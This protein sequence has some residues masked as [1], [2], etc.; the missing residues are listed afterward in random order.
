MALHNDKIKKLQDLI[1]MYTFPDKRYPN[2]L[3]EITELLVWANQTYIKSGIT[4]EQV[5]EIL[6]EPYIILHT[7]SPQDF[8]WLYPQLD[9]SDNGIAGE[10]FLH[11][12]FDE[13]ILI[14]I[15]N[16]HGHFE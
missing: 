9:E 16:T 6:G 1:T 11:L 7:N 3:K 10:Y 8:E 13:N 12:Y 2:I 5:R 14:K 4:S 15:K